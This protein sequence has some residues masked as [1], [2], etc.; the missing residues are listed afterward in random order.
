MM[1]RVRNLAIG[2][3]LVA[4]AACEPPVAPA[5]APAAPAGAVAPP[6]PAAGFS[7]EAT[8]DQSGYYMPV[9]ETKIGNW[10]LDHMF[11]GQKFEFTAW[12]GGTRSGTFGPLMIEF[13]DTS[14]PT[15]TNELGQVGHTVRSR[16]LP[17]SYTVTDDRVRFAGRSAELGEVTFDGRLDAGALA[18]ARRNLGGGEAAVLT[19]TLTVGERTLTGQSFR[20]YGGD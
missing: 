6:T 15:Q 13:S 18:T 3:T 9:S 7:H 14:S 19:G 8:V 12:Q 4:L 2:L 11:M 1:L 20:W 16:V 5:D 10:R 17:T